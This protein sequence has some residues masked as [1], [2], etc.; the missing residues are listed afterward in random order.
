MTASQE[1][2][3][4][5]PR[6]MY[7]TL[8]PKTHPPHLLPDETEQEA[9]WERWMMER[10]MRSPSKQ[11]RS[12]GSWSWLQSE[13]ARCPQTTPHPLLSLSF[14]P[15]KIIHRWAQFFCTPLGFHT[16]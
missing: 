8:D 5:S 10:W 2:C 1:A 4:R 16:L 15:C 13:L 9:H 14:L 12:P 3:T 11:V 6:G 7:V